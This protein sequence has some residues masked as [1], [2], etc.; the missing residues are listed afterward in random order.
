MSEKDNWVV[1]NDVPVSVYSGHKDLV[2]DH[3][4]N[5]VTD[6]LVGVKDGTEY[7]RC[8]SCYTEIKRV[9]KGDSSSGGYFGR[10]RCSRR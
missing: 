10:R 8:L 4:C 5:M 9:C 3:G 6:H 1:V 7:R 2:C